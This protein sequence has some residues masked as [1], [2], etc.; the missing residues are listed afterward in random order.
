MIFK[1]WS[2]KSSKRDTVDGTV[3]VSPL[4]SESHLLCV[5]KTF[6]LG[7]GSLAYLSLLLILQEC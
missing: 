2:I 7:Y 1:N 6:V 4:F 3:V 5:V